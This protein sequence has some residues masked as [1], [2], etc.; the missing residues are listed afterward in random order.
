M[1]IPTRNT[2]ARQCLQTVGIPALPRVY[3]AVAL[4]K[5]H[6]LHATR[7]CLM[8]VPSL[9]GLATWRSMRGASDEGP[10]HW[11]IIRACAM[12]HEGTEE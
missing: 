11:G 9:V 6:G 10:F 1:A 8:L 5:L 12:I 7:N 4:N 3:R 2:Q